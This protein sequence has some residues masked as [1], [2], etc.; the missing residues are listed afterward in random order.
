MHLG[1]C[2]PGRDERQEAYEEPELISFEWDQVFAQGMKRAVDLL[3]NAT[4]DAACYNVTQLTGPAGP[5]AAWIY[6]WCAR[7]PALLNY[8][9]K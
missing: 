2:D 5:G 3:Y 1:G 7:F 9:R 6:Q 8:D 4:H